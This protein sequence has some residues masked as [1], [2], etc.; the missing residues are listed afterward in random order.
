MREEFRE[1][2]TCYETFAM[3]P[4]PK[5]LSLFFVRENVSI[6]QAIGKKLFSYLR[7][8]FTILLTWL[9]YV[10]N[11]LTFDPGKTLSPRGMS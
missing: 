5:L 3:F 10:S 6:L 1:K 2:K 8:S 11:A 7:P 4:L 9:F